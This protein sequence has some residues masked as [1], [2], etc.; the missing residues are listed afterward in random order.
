M[1]G[2]GRRPVADEWQTPKATNV[3]TPVTH[4]PERSDGGQPNLA[5][6]I[7]TGAAPVVLNPRWVACLMGFP[8]D[9]LDGVEVPSKR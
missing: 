6:Q 8:P 5:R 9:Y 7:Q 2:V 1:G 4:H 3:S